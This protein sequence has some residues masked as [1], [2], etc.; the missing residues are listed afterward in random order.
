M[1][2]YFYIC[3]LG[4]MLSC[5]SCFKDDTNT[6]YRE[7]VKPV[8]VNDEKLPELFVE[9][10][11]YSVKYGD[12]LVITPVISYENMNDLEYEWRVD[13]KTIC[14]TKDFRWTCDISDRSVGTFVIRRKS[15]GNADVYGF[16]VALNQPYERGWSV[17]AKDDNEEVRLHFLQE[18]VASPEYLYEEWMDAMGRSLSYTN[19]I[20][21]MEYWST[22]TSSVKSELLYLDADPTKCMNMDG[23]SLGET[24]SLQQEFRN[25]TF[26]EGLQVKDAMY[27]GFIT[28]ILDKNGKLYQRKAGYGYYTGQYSDRPV[29]FEGKE[30]SVSALLPCAY[31]SKM[32]LMFDSGNGRFLLVETDYSVKAGGATGTKAGRIQKFP[33]NSGLNTLSGQELAWA[34]FLKPKYSYN[35]IYSYFCILKGTDNVYRARQFQVEYDGD[36]LSGVTNDF[37]EVVFPGFGADSKICVLNDEYM[38]MI[39]PCIYFTK[40]GDPYSLYSCTR[41]ASGLA[42][43]TL[44]KKFDSPIVG[45][46]HSK[47]SRTASYLGVALKNGDLMIFNLTKD[48]M[49]E[50]DDSLV[51]TWHGLGQILELN[52]KYGNVSNV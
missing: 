47:L 18:I 19:P 38:G 6:N 43:P 9:N 41:S 20:R 4:L 22:E 8:L 42:S 36:V 35:P 12:E 45:L 1:N 30:L 17:L 33:D 29:E 40:E 16:T 51:K 27:C 52:Y 25:E 46:D 48:Y 21:V 44:Y 50:V 10:H 24:V 31:P 7:L 34:S 39:Q 15:A 2:R 28:Y 23:L 13:G 14:T 11:A 26:P 3:L 32:G 37:K 5:V 49:K